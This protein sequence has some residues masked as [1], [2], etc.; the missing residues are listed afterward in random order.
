MIVHLI[1]FRPRMQ[2]WIY[3]HMCVTHLYYHKTRRI[4]RLAMWAQLLWKQVIY[5]SYNGLLL[6]TPWDTVCIEKDTKSRCTSSSLIKEKRGPSQHHKIKQ[7]KLSVQLHLR[8][9]RSWSKVCV[10]SWLSEVGW[11]QEMNK[12]HSEGH[13][14][15]YRC[16][17]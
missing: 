3:C 12:V 8:K 2:D 14:L 15:G 5:T 7:L 6:R 17:F 13:N 11:L 16:S 9:R 1:M 4:G 10:L